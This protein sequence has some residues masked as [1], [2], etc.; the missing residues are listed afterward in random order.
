MKHSDVSDKLTGLAVIAESDKYSEEAK[1][2]RKHLELSMSRVISD[3]K[4]ADLVLQIGDDGLTLIGNGQSL[5][6]DFSRMLP[7]V[8][9]GRL[10]GELLVKAAKIKGFGGTPMA[11]DATAGLGEDSF[12]LASAGFSVQLYERDPVIA[13]LLKDAL[14]R[15]AA[16]PELS[17]I[18]GRMTLI[19]ADSQTELLEI[20]TSPDMVLLDPMFPARQK[21]ALVKKKL[22]LFQKLE[23][24][25]RDETALL[26]AALS[27]HPRKIVVKRPLNGPYLADRKPDYSIKGKTIRYDCIVLPQNGD[28]L[29]QKAGK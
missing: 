25:C 21:S 13:A 14:L 4:S 11:I 12:L 8:S 27:A 9:R 1:T 3:W 15:A 29:I 23:S 18:A 16:V 6:G 20:K 24:P 17:E 26:N 10:H 7:R 28:K 22:Q 2:L 19:E 5:R